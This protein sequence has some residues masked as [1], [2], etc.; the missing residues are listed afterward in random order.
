MFEPPKESRPKESRK[1]NSLLRFS[2][3]GLLFL[4]LLVA[5]GIKWHQYVQI[6][7]KETETGETLV[8]SGAE[9]LSYH[10]G[11]SSRNIESF[12][13]N[14]VHL[15][16]LEEL[17]ALPYLK[18]ASLNHVFIRRQEIDF[19]K[20]CPRFESLSLER[21]YL[22]KP[23]EKDL[24]WLSKLDLKLPGTLYISNHKLTSGMVEAINDLK[25][26]TLWLQYCAFEKVA[27]QSFEVDFDSQCVF[28]HYPN[29]TANE[30]FSAFGEPT[31]NV[32]FKP[33]RYA[34][35]FLTGASD[36]G[37]SDPKRH[38]S[39]VPLA[40]GIGFRGSGTPLNNF[41]NLMPNLTRICNRHSDDI[42]LNQLILDSQPTIHLHCFNDL[43][44]DKPMKPG[45]VESMVEATPSL[46]GLAVRRLL[47]ESPL[48]FTTQHMLKR[49]EIL[50][51]GEFEPAFFTEVGKLKQLE[52]LVIRNE[53]ELGSEISPI[54]D[55]E[56]L[57]SLRLYREKLSP[58]ALKMIQDQER[59]ELLA[60]S[61]YEKQ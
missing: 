3:K 60:A 39:A 18:S 47:P 22:D 59:I 37:Y 16:G 45:H 7:R 5:S 35:H 23:T 43:P 29:F 12:K 30:L 34:T 40:T 32:Y 58:D 11:E 33:A 25:F 61:Q 17:Y 54:L 55:L 28:F 10:Y 2:I 20:R 46:E 42:G 4:I 57:K 51:G 21:C 8:Q 44:S 9:V 26:E 49:L 27:L 48:R 56:H 53:N 15:L 24:V 52:E 19:L 14:S 50:E 31:Y 1:R 6:C 36:R 38:Q 41:F 13:Y